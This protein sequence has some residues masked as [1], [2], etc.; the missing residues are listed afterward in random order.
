[1]ESTVVHSSNVNVK[2]Y[3]EDVLAVSTVSP[4][5]S[6][7]KDI[8]L[9][10]VVALS[11]RE[12]SQ[13]SLLHKV[14]EDHTGISTWRSNQI[15][16]EPKKSQKNPIE[17]IHT[18]N[19][20]IIK[21]SFCA[22]GLLPE[23]LVKRVYERLLTKR[24]TVLSTL[25]TGFNIKILA[26]NE[27]IKVFLQKA[28]IKAT[29]QFIPFD[30]AFLR[31]IV[32][33]ERVPKRLLPDLPFS[34]N[35][36]NFPLGTHFLNAQKAVGLTQ[37][38]GLI[39]FGGSEQHLLLAA[40]QHYIQSL[41]ITGKKVVILDFDNELNGFISALALRQ[42]E[43][44]PVTVFQLGRNLNL[45]LCGIDTPIS[46]ISRKSQLTYQATVL[47][48]I[49]AF[50]SGN[51]D[52]QANL[53]H[54]QMKILET[55]EILPLRERSLKNILFSDKFTDSNTD[56][57][58]TLME[59]LQAGLRLY[60]EFPELNSHAF[61]QEYATRLTPQPG[62]TLF[63]F[64]VPLLSI[65]RVIFAFLMHTLAM[66][67][68]RETIVIV[69]NASQIF[70][71]EYGEREGISAKLY[72]EAL[73]N[74]FSQIT[75]LSCL[76]LV[77][78][79]LV[80]LHLDIQQANN[81]GI[82]FRFSSN[83]DRE[84]IARRYALTR[85][86]EDPNR[87]LQSLDGEGLLLNQSTPNTINHFVPYTLSPVILD[88]SF[89]ERVYLLSES[90]ELT[91]KQFVNLMI[92]LEL[93]TKT[94]VEKALLLHQLTGSGIKTPSAQLQEFK[95]RGYIIEQIQGEKHLFS[96]SELGNTLFQKYNDQIVH[97][98]PSLNSDEY[99][100]ANIKEN[101]RERVHNIELFDDNEYQQLVQDIQE[102]IGALLREFFSTQNKI[103]WGVFRDY[104][105]LLDIE[106]ETDRLLIQ[107]MELLERIYSDLHSNR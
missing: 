103:D 33:L 78:Y 18:H 4:Q 42:V 90:E 54:L 1:M 44:L 69:T 73:G 56:L 72:T 43:N 105:T 10:S 7:K 24:T 6:F 62:V 41:A 28:N 83:E 75:R 59:Q 88:P 94:D 47:T 76:T 107:R 85:Y 35:P 92:I 19:Y 34:N 60:T 32:E 102:F 64:P 45:N 79:S 14:V 46:L 91:K 2:F 39:I 77:T 51:S 38:P 22:Y 31:P 8:V 37:Q 15:T 61:T 99:K 93:L 57:E 81:T 106:D 98:P 17:I 3:Q 89:T 25:A 30:K 96:I 52:I 67:C 84:W 100:L 13:F 87:F 20:L 11:A 82:Y 97:L 40:L 9:L 104:I 23:F 26:N 53:S 12:L 101:L 63:Q 80:R 16:E 21:E 70:T 5:R 55:I 58:F 65:K 74:S 36:V 68:D 48:N 95:K 29:E 27:L 50:A 49:L 86:M 66:R 71:Q